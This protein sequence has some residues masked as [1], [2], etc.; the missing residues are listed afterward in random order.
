MSFR[1]VV[2][3]TPIHL[4]PTKNTDAMMLSRVQAHPG[5]PATLDQLVADLNSR[6]DG[7]AATVGA[8]KQPGNDPSL[9]LY[10]STCV[11]RLFPTNH[12][13]G[14]L[15]ASVDPLRIRDHHQLAQACLVIRP[16][17]WHRV[18]TV[19]MLP[20]GASS[21]WE[22]LLAEWQ[23]VIHRPVADTPVPNSAHTRYLDIVAALIDA[24]QRI[25]ADAA[26]HERPYPYREVNPIGERRHGTASMY[27]FRLVDGRVP[28]QDTFVQ[29]RG[30]PEQRGQVT[31]ADATAVVV[32]FDQLI[33]FA[34]I[35]QTGALEITPSTVVFDK[36][37]EAVALVREGQS[38]NRHLLAAFVDHQVRPFTAH[39]DVPTE[40]LD[41]DQLLAFRKSL[42][43]PD[44]L[45]VLGPPGT[46]KTR[47]I[48]QVARAAALGVPGQRSRQRVLVTSHTNRAVD[49]VLTRIPR[50]LVVVRV[51]NEGGV[52]EEGKPYLL[53]R[54]SLELRQTILNQTGRVLD[55]I[56][57]LDVAAKWAAELTDRVAVLSVALDEETRSRT[58]LRQAQRTAG[59]A[60]AST[61]E[62][63]VTQDAKLSR[64]LAKVE[65][66]GQRYERWRGA[67]GGLFS[68]WCDKRL[69]TLRT[70]F[71]Q[72]SA[73]VQAGRDELVA[74]ERR[75][76]ETT[77]EAPAVR[78]AHAEVTAAGQRAGEARADAMTA[79][80]ATRAAVGSFDAPPQVNDDSDLHALVT[81]AA[82]R[83]PLARDRARLLEEWRDEVAGASKQL[84][85]E[86]I[87]YADVIACTAIGAASRSELSDVDFDLAIVDEAG[88]I[89]MADA[90][91]PL[92]RSRRAVLVGDHQQLP[93]FLDSEVEAWGDEVGD[94]TVRRLLAKSALELA[95]D[96]FP[97]ANVVPL[98]W[99]RRMP[100]VIADFIS[101]SFYR[102]TLHTDV[103]REHGDPLFR[104]AFAFVDTARLPE[105][106]RSERP[107]DE[108]NRNV[109]GCHN[110]AEAR[111]LTKLAEH[112]DE[113]G[114]E[115]AVIVPYRAQVKA[116]SAALLAALGDERKVRLNVGTVD[117]FQ[118]GERDVILYGFTRSNRDGHVG[119]LRELR[120]ANVA[121][122]RAKHQLVLVGDLSMLTRAL[123]KGFRDLACDLRDHVARHGDI[124]QY[125]E[126]IGKL[127]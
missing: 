33:D 17:R 126:I 39:P 1:L 69:R 29:V 9:L 55:G 37:R 32:R 41:D 104:S 28:E 92:V 20:A 56:G 12:R 98:T 74:V 68:S 57:D 43:V 25:T 51:G 85:P 107:A 91:V 118:G 101:T 111:L 23:V 78:A 10:G 116:I 16:P 72:L 103:D 50:E 61:V 121:F 84:H 45:L 26:R 40:Q 108:E 11:I 119:F 75:L 22:R 49:N 66:A 36:Q 18:F 21:H 2:L 86:L 102:G 125:D 3:P 54:L 65:R 58:R 31:R 8:P 113:R 67:V 94:E 53:E 42:A 124:R 97:G 73:A 100:A 6:P 106:V 71:E 27:E 112:Y 89:G 114:A 77:R 70:R 15:I 83:I 96:G 127:G 109:R 80:N 123:D 81:W 95:V 5:M 24:N 4:V 79:A 110:P 60:L 59:G 120:R 82:E 48:S 62:L 13:D 34:R 115:W 46:G 63:L 7:V 99:Q 38:L 47:V 122:T 87:R 44:V 105:A 52:T 76:D 88:Q 64:K 90:L 35:E 19:R 93:P 14:Y 117:S 30:E